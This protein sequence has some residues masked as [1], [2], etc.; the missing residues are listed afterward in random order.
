MKK[1]LKGGRDSSIWR[2]PAAVSMIRP[3][4][5]A[6]GVAVAQPVLAQDEERINAAP[7]VVTPTRVEQSAFDLPVSIDAFDQEVIQEGKPQV[8]LSEVLIRAP[9][10]VANNRQNYAQDLQISIRG[11][12]ARSAFGVRGI[13]LIAD[14]IPLTMPDGSGQA[15]NIDLNSAQRVEVLRGPF[16]ALYGNSSGGVIN[17]ITEDGP[18]AHTVT[19]NGWFGSFDSSKLGLKFGGQQGSLNY[20]LNASRFDTDGYRDHSAATRDTANAK[21]KY[22]LGEDTDLTFL[23]NY[24]TQPDTQD[25]Q[26]LTKAEADANPEQASPNA[27][28][29]NTRKSIDNV[30]TG[31]VLQKRISAEDSIRVLGYVGDRQVTQFLSVPTGA[32]IPPGSGGGV[33]DL[34]RQFGGVDLRW[35]RVSEVFSRAATITLGANYDRQEERRRGYEN[36]VGTILGVQGTLRRDEDNVVY[37]FDQF[38]Q[39][40]MA[41]TERVLL[42]AGLRYS[43]IKFDSTDYFVDVISG[44][45][46]DS[47]SLEFS[48]TTPVA[49]VVFK[50][51]PVFNVYANAGKGFE[52]PTF[53]EL[54]YRPSGQGAGLNSQLL[55]T[56][57]NNYEV[58][59]KV[60]FGEHTLVNAA[61]FKIDGKNELVV[62]SNNGG[63]S[64]FQNAGKTTREGAE[65]SISSSLGQG[66]SAFGAFTYLVA[67]YD[68]P[69][70]ACVT[71]G[72]AAADTTIPAGNRIPGIPETTF[73]GEL[74]WRQN[75]KHGFYSLAEVRWVDKIYVNDTNSEAA[76]GYIVANLSVGRRWD[77]GDVSVNSFGRVENVFDKQYI[78]SVIVNASGSRYYEP[79]PGRN[80]L[81]GV[82]A[83]YAF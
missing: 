83:S 68:E 56:E 45:G 33:I 58:G 41:V 11:F 46:D 10:V 40:E 23:V 38:I 28:L 20:V 81:M 70:L 4:C 60:F 55:P 62:F 25:P 15:A 32:Q 36:F 52:T 35:T 27:L 66:F 29:F 6:I 8:N 79:A 31:L 59:S 78:G 47:G 12:G 43:K 13:R 21:L 1:S 5:L 74:S 72:C 48:E 54:A 17:V 82:T 57:S 9:G 34:D 76:E 65:L 42:S 73:F 51:T 7:I 18:E 69:F 2:A 19:G 64:V 63:R 30:Q 44:N 39:G 24:L 3:F 61:I 14:G 53:A 71:P 75:Q 49:G 80:Y 50:V 37:N 67:E 16:S 26:G 22:M 77:L